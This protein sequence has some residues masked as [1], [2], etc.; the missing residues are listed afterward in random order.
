VPPEGAN[1]GDPERTGVNLRVT[2]NEV[3]WASPGLGFRYEATDAVTV[4]GGVHRGYSPPTP[5]SADADAEEA[6]NYELGARWA[7]AVSSRTSTSTR[8]RKRSPSSAR[9]SV[10]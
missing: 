3:D 9:P 6:V 1:P 7:G 5:G 2:E 8:S 4:F 10:G